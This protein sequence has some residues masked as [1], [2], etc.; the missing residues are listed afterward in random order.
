MQRGVEMFANEV[1][2]ISLWPENRQF[3]AAADMPWAPI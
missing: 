3:E 1:F 2:I